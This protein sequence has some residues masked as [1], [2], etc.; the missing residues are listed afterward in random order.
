MITDVLEVVLELEY[1]LDDL[2]HHPLKEA[3]EVQYMSLLGLLV[4]IMDMITRGIISKDSL[5]HLEMIS[6]GDMILTNT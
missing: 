3:S 4:R 5:D 2:V 1:L 6:S